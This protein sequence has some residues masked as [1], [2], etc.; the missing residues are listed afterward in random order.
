MRQAGCTC[1]AV[2]ERLDARKVFWR[3]NQ[4]TLI[5]KGRRMKKFSVSLL[6]LIVLAGCS[7][8]RPELGIKNGRLI[9]CPQTPNCVSSQDVDEKHHIEPIQFMG[10]QDEAH[11]R[12]RKILESE[13]RTKFVAISDDYIW[14]EFTSAFFGFTDDVEFYFPE[15]QMGEVVIHVR[16][17][18]RIGY[19][20]FGVNQK[21]VELLRKKL[22]ETP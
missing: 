2:T 5:K 15:K 21:R 18:S 1:L 20:D 6:S 7:G 14:A 13:Q 9:P 12:L 17:A 3:F 19:S 4:Q 10:T 16:S 11:N 8:T 22:T